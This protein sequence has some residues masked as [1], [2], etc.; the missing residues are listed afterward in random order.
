MPRKSQPFVH[1]GPPTVS[2]PRATAM[3]AADSRIPILYPPPLSPDELRVITREGATDPR[4]RGTDR[5]L[6]RWSVTPGFTLSWPQLAQVRFR[7]G[8]SER[9]TPLPDR[10]GQLVDQA[11]KSS[12]LWA[13]Q[14]V[15]MW[16]RSDRTAQE[17]AEI[18]GMRRRQAVYEE[19][20][21]V[22]AYYFGRL[23]QMGIGIAAW[24]WE[25]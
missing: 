21:M 11:V 3:D 25:A 16:Y 9:P 4:L 20:H 22:L 14:F 23:T 1:R 6:Q 12:P 2:A 8:Q 18:L 5:C 10:E 13:R 24:D 19:R 15:I 17:M 7:A